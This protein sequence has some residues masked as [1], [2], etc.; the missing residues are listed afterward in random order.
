MPKYRVRKLPLHVE[1]VDSDNVKT[2]NSYK[3][4]AEVE[5]TEEQASKHSHLVE[6]TD[7]YNLREK[8]KE[9]RRSTSRGKG[10]EEPDK[11]TETNIA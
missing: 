6:T 5:L 4:F 1:T 10:K 8:G 2:R 3:P 7:Q 9:K 11:P